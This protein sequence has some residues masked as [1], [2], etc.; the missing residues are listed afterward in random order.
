MDVLKDRVAKHPDEAFNIFPLIF[1]TGFDI[2]SGTP[3]KNMHKIFCIVDNVVN[4]SFGSKQ[5]PL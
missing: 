4:L 5:N 1:D 2:I 3:K